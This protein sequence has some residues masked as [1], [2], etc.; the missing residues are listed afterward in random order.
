MSAKSKKAAAKKKNEKKNRERA[1]LAAKEAL[2]QKKAAQAG[3]NTPKKAPE[4]LKAADS[5][6]E[7]QRAKEEKQKE[8]QRL[9]EKKE[10]EK[11]EK[12]KAAQLEKARLA[13]EKEQALKEKLKNKQSKANN[14]KQT[15][16]PVKKE[17]PVNN[18]AGQKED[19]KAKPGKPEK[20]KPE[21]SKP[22]KADA[23]QS[24]VDVNTAATT[25]ETGDDAVSVESVSPEEKDD[26]V[27]VTAEE[28]EKKLISPLDEILNEI[29]GSA[30]I[31]NAMEQE[32]P[33]DTAE[34][35]D[36]EA[37][38]PEIPVTVADGSSVPKDESDN[39]DDDD[40]N[41]DNDDDD[42]IEEDEERNPPTANEPQ[43]GSMRSPLPFNMAHS[44]NIDAPLEAGEEA[45]EPESPVIVGDGS[46]V[47]NEESDDEDIAEEESSIPEEAP[48][49]NASAGAIAGLVLQALTPPQENAA[50]TT[51]ES[52]TAGIPEAEET[53]EEEEQTE[54]PEPL[55]VVYENP[56]AQLVLSAL[57]APQTTGKPA[58]ADETAAPMV[59][60]ATPEQTVKTP[61]FKTEKPEK[62][63]KEP[64]PK[65]EKPVKPPGEPKPVKQKQAKEPKP[66]KQ[67]KEKEV[68]F[69]MA[70]ALLINKAATGIKEKTADMTRK[71]KVFVAAGVVAVLIFAAAAVAVSVF[72]YKVPANA[73]PVYMGRVEPGVNVRDIEVGQEEQLMKADETPAKGSRAIKFFAYTNLTIDEWYD[74]V[75]LVLGN[76][77][78]NT[79]DF[80]V[81]VLDKDD[82]IVYRSM[83]I[84]PGK[85]LPYFKLF[86]EMPYGAYD[87]TVVVAGYNPQTFE[88]IGV[89]YMKLKLVIG[90]EQGT[91]KETGQTE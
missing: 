85:Y 78:T 45:D 17:K 56:L 19:R 11:R 58:Q 28:A 91:Q 55:P 36:E 75:P 10:K 66:P 37:D 32:V 26:E 61:E 47:P 59:E 81:T 40:D 49:S 38:K 86:D 54:Q 12:R 82:R 33:E 27:F 73:V 15:A 31:K 90:F 51:E 3:G 22:I 87:L 1:A 83:G 69:K 42:D 35:H 62:P 79:C 60:S 25:A 9:K 8:K 70:A 68:S 16:A 57:S 46:S 64:K 72:S 4:K 24:P 41:D 50:E 18:T 84:K 76:V 2:E 39:D 71:T 88:N 6:K 74:E 20:A 14:K 52:E 21:K 80:I 34:I 5:S 44:E 7:K 30:A 63:A 77:Q 89:K 23:G 67:K 13:K 29:R 43:G 53:P 65:K 48:E